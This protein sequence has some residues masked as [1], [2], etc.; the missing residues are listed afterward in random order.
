MTVNCVCSWLIPEWEPLRQDTGP[1]H[2]NWRDGQEGSL[3]PLSAPTCFSVNI[4]ILTRNPTDRAPAP[5]SSVSIRVRA[6]SVIGSLSPSPT[7]IQYLY[8]LRFRAAIVTFLL[9]NWQPT[10]SLMYRKCFITMG[11]AQ[12]LIMHGN[13][14]VG[15][16]KGLV[17]LCR[18]TRLI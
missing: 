13:M 1:W 10:S 8:C 9:S 18:I 3:P 16:K 5:L 17:S 15:K 7:L 4:Y 14:L 11:R 12:P 6:P 2:N